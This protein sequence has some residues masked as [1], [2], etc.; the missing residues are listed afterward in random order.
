MIV[1]DSASATD[2]TRR[3]AASAGVRYL[4]CDVAGASLA[5]NAGVAAASHDVVAFTDDDC[6]PQPG[7]AAALE[8]MFE[9]DATLGWVTGAVNA[10]GADGS[11]STEEVPAGPWTGS[12]DPMRFG[13]GA[14]WACRRDA[15]AAVGGFDEVMGPGAPLLAAEDQ[16]LFWR[17]LRAGWAG[18]HA[19]DAE[20]RHPAWR[21][22]T[23][24]LRVEWTYGVGTGAL[25]AKAT[26][27]GDRDGP[28][29]RS[30]L[31]D[32][33]AVRIVDLVVRRRLGTAARQSVRTAGTVVGRVRAR[34]FAI[35][36]DGRFRP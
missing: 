22:R 16:D 2:A 20:V 18:D 10:S 28:R 12:R 4:R 9:R 23:M 36:E 21:D 1:V 26:R 6:C 15:F 24:M 33:G 34:R 7:W 17:L 29:L 5:R 25:T 32:E 27:L 3:V 31:W 30:R 19:H 35:G 8:R 13:H 14:N 11:L